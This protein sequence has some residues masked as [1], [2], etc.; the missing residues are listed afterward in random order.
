MKKVALCLSGLVGCTKG[1]GD[2]EV[3]D[4]HLGF[5]HLKKHILAHNDV[6]VF[7]HC[8]NKELEEEFKDL[9][10]PLDSIF[11]NQKI[12]EENY[13]TRQHAISSRWYSNKKVL[14]LKRNYEL[15]HGITYDWVMLTRFDIAFLKDFVFSKFTNGLLHTLGTDPIHGSNCSLPCCIKRSS[16]YEVNDLWFFGS[17]QI[18]DTFANVFSSLKEYGLESNHVITWKHIKKNGLDSKRKVVFEQNVH[19]E[20]G[21]G[22][23]PLVR[24]YYP[25]YH[26][27]VSF[28]TKLRWKI[29]W[30]MKKYPKLGKLV[31][32]LKLCIC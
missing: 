4:Y 32:L 30:L 11:E 12:F 13:T 5:K 10:N 6:D 28:F 25:Q 29:R 17:S 21:I 9:Y 3:L 23:S 19:M 24:W 7:I 14:E 18:M 2:G 8:W 20:P 31:K 1:E 26:P 15:K 16:K 22:D 27:K